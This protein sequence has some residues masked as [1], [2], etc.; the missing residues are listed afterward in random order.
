MTKNMIKFQ[1]S[2]GF[3]HSFPLSPCF[4]QTFHHAFSKTCRILLNPAI[5][6]LF[7]HAFAA[8]F[9]MI[10]P[11]LPFFTKAAVENPPMTLFGNHFWSA[12]PPLSPIIQGL[13][14]TREQLNFLHNPVIYETKWQSPTSSTSGVKHRMQN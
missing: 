12:S 4:F 3:H 1:N 6:S 10:H 13:G 11:M 2:E 9:T 8:H 7:H 5:P 14:Y